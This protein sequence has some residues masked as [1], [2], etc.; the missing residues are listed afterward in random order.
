MSYRT[1]AKS[2]ESTR[3][4]RMQNNRDLAS[5]LIQRRSEIEVRMRDVLGAAAPSAGAPETETLRRF[6][7]YSGAALVRERPGSPPIDGLRPNERRAMALLRAWVHAAAEVAGDN[8]R[9]VRD[10]LDPLVD[11]FRIALRATHSGRRSAGAPRASR[12]AVVAAIDRVSDAFLAVDCDNGRIVDA[13]PAA[14][15]LLGVD[16]DAL[17]AVDAISFIPE[18]SRPQWEEALDSVSESEEGRELDTKMRDAHMEDLPVSVRIT[19]FATRRRTLALVMARPRTAHAR[20]SAVAPGAN[21]PENR[22]AG[23]NPGVAASFEA[24]FSRT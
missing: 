7:S 13:N 14:G 18:E 10:S 8:G 15:A 12:R 23:P 17:L 21:S 6:R 20:P 2:R 4:P 5:W 3:L 11:R 22:P 24:T 16:R 9:R 1:L 19:C